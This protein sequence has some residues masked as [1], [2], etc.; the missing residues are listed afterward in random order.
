MKLS[1]RIKSSGTFFH[2]LDTLNRRIMLWIVIDSVLERHISRDVLQS[3][4][5]ANRHEGNNSGASTLHLSA[6]TILDFTQ[7]TRRG[8][9]SS[10]NAVMF[11]FGH[12]HGSNQ[13]LSGTAGIPNQTFVYWNMGLFTGPGAIPNLTI[14]LS[15]V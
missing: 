9:I 14:S 8:A 11:G 13:N 6:V 1:S 7:W 12:K 4:A 5:L 3:N 15:L 2:G 10:A